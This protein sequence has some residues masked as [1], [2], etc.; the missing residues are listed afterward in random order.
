TVLY[1]DVDTTNT[2][3]LRARN[4][5][6]VRVTGMAFQG[7]TSPDSAGTEVGVQMDSTVDF[8]V[9]HCFFTRTGRSGVWTSGSSSGVVDH[10][11]FEDLFKIQVNNLGYGIEVG[12]MNILEGEPFGSARATFVEDSSFRRCRHAVAS[13][14]GARYVSRHNYVGQNQVAHT[15]DAHGHEFGSSVGTEWVDVHDNWIEDPADAVSM[16]YAV[17]IRGGMGLVWNNFFIG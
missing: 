2:V 10:C 9:D 1:R 13:N 6:R 14:R 15:V 11:E 17:R 8:R 16:R 5:Q 3:M 4:R 7:V 12:A